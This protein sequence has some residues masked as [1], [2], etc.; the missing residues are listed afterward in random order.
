MSINKD[1]YGILGIS[2]DEKKLHGEEFNSICKKKYRTLALK[3][4]PDRWANA[5]DEEKKSAE[6]KFKEIAEAYEVLSDQ[7]KRNQYDNGFMDFNGGIDP[8]EMFRRMA[9]NF[10]GM[11]GFGS[12]FDDDFGHERVSKGSNTE[13]SVTLTLEEA[14]RGV[15]K[16]VTVRR[17][18]LCSHCNGTGSDD[19]K[20]S[21]CPH[22]NGSGFMT[23]TTQFGP[24]QFSMTRSVCP[25]CGGSGKLISKPCKHCNGSGLETETTRETIHIPRGLD[26]GVVMKVAGLGN[27]PQDSNGISGDLM[28]HVNIKGDSY[29]ERYDAM[30]L[31][32]YE[33]VP[34]N[35][36]LLGFTK[37]V[38]CIDGSNV[39]LKAPELTKDNQAFVFHGK[40]MPNM[41]NNSVFGDYAVVVKY[42]MPKKLNDKQKEILK[43]FNDL[44]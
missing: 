44:K 24:G 43:N 5:S 39:T 16:E 35:E 38:K 20:S 18:K 17:R 8:M 9:Q 31:V 40:G 30:N 11:G 6:D 7:N 42:K 29:F 10:G 14:Y 21:T 27:M 36:A 13:A 34:F 15:D 33:E 3:Y 1:Y 26:D 41:N 2:D 12:F 4:H 22:C 25:N 23:K 37:K 32:H 19:G 28:L